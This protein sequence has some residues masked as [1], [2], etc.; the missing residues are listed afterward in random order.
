MH[1]RNKSYCKKYDTGNEKINARLYCTKSQDLKKITHHQSSYTG[2]K[3]LYLQIAQYFFYHYQ[4]SMTIYR[5]QI[6]AN[7]EQ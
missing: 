6:K 2:I 3:F 1:S 4:K 5:K 7:Y